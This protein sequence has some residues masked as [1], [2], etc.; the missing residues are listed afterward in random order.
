MV[1][2]LTATALFGKSRTFLQLR[3]T[4]NMHQ[5]RVTQYLWSLHETNQS[6]I[7]RDAVKVGME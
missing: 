5:L 1:T 4:W 2:A 3:D 6:W 7:N